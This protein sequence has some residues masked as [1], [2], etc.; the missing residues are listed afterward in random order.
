MIQTLILN[1]VVIK[2]IRKYSMEEKE[3]V[4]EL[5]LDEVFWECEVVQ[6]RALYGVV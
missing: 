4:R 3:D 1:S 6:E 5:M 2:F